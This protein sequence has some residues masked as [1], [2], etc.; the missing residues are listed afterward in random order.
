[1]GLIDSKKNGIVCFDNNE[2][3]ELLM[4]TQCEIAFVCVF[5]SVYVSECE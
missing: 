2:Q 4:K 3:L 5:V 1:M